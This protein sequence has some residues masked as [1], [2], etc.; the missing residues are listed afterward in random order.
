M[1]HNGL[2]L[3]FVFFLRTFLVLWHGIRTFCFYQ[4]Q[5]HNAHDI[6]LGHMQTETP[7]MQPSPGAL[8]PFSPSSFLSDP[9][10][11]DCDEDGDIGC[12]M[13]WALRIL[14]SADIFIYSAGLYSFFQNF[15][16]TCLVGE[17][18]QNGVIETSYTEGLWLYNLF[19]IGAV[20]A[21]SPRGGIDPVLQNDTQR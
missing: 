4:Y 2:I 3:V 21:V 7:Y 8:R 10:F 20:Q 6:F 15:G 14:S 16:K 18:C 13:A 19:T 17:N 11:P 1:Y 12:E 5:L 9:T